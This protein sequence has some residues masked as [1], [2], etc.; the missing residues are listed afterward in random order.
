MIDPFLSQQRAI[1][2]IDVRRMIK[3]TKGKNMKC[4]SRAEKGR[5]MI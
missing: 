1:P 3:Q 5:A 2:M 4:P